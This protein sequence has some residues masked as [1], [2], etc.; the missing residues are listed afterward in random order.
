MGALSTSSN[1]PLGAA[2]DGI[3]LLFLLLYEVTGDWLLGWLLLAL[4]YLAGGGGRP[5]LIGGGGI[6]PLPLLVVRRF[7]GG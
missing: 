1:Y 2:N 6:T 7:V 3:V 5:L 4:G